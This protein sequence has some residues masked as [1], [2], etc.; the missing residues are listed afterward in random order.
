MEQEAAKELLRKYQA[1]ECTDKEKSL[2]ENAFLLY[3]EHDID[4]SPEKIAEMGKEV[5]SKLPGAGGLE[6][7]FKLGPVIT[8]IAAVSLIGISAWMFRMMPEPELILNKTTD[9]HPGGNKATLEFGDGRIIDLRKDRESI[10][11]GKN[12]IKYSDGTSV[13]DNNTGLATIRTPN[14]G[15]YQIVLSDGTKVWL[16]AASTLQ[17]PAV[18][19]ERTARRVRLVSGEA[20]F[21]VF[22]DKK[23]KFILETNK[24]EIEVLGTH[25]NV[26]TYQPSNI[27]TTLLEGSVKVSS[28]HDL[29]ISFLKPGEQSY[30][31]GDR[32]I[33]KNVDVDLN[34]AWKKGKIQFEREDLKTVMDMLHRW[35]N[36]DVIY[37]SYPN[38]ARFTGSISRSRNISEVLKLLENT[39]EVHFK[40]QGKEVIVMK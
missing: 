8:T 16:N 2:V 31:N 17:Y 12:N 5:Y 33:V 38:Q 39:D 6:G 26:N 11:I 22:K 7:G 25:F 23:R 35:Y 13:T 29:K 10:V 37:K 19:R 1:G 4:I 21:E 9:I 14:G 32:R 3:N 15:Q 27:K 28:E 24:Q 30:Y 18:F 20:Y 36:I 34:I 40:I